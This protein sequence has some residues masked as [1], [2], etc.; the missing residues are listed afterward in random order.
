[1]SSRI[2]AILSVLVLLVI[3]CGCET[4]SGPESADP[5]A[6]DE[7]S[8]VEALALA[9][10]WRSSFPAVTTTLKSTSIE[11]RFSDGTERSISVPAGEMIVAVAPY[12]TNTHPCAIHSISGCTGEL[13]DVPMRVVASVSD[14]DTILDEVRTTL[15]N[16][17]LELSLPSHAQIDLYLEYGGKTATGRISTYETDNTCVTTFKLD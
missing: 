14:G 9:N 3:S 12:L 11:F 2:R 13:A 6:L 1:M 7:L 10:A 8:A 4:T 16:G 17:F 15:S 5:A